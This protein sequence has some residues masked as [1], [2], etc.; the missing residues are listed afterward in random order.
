MRECA[1]V[2]KHF[3]DVK[4][5]TPN[6]DAYWKEI[7]CGKTINLYKDMKG[8]KKKSFTLEKAAKIKNK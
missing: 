2:Q 7:F 4:K 5:N 6:S 1:I 8:Q 3:T